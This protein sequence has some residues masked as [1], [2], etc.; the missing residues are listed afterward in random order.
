MRKSN[1]L[2]A[3]LLFGLLAALAAHAQESAD[4]PVELNPDHPT[5]YVV[6]Q[7]DTLWSIAKQFLKEPWRWPHVWH[8]NPQISNPHL[9]YP[10]DTIELTITE[11]GPVLSLGRGSE[12]RISPRVRTMA[13]EKAIPAIPIDAIHQFLTRPLVVNEGELEAAPYV[14]ALQE[15]HIIG[16]EGNRIYVRG[17]DTQEYESFDVVR[18]G[19]PYKDGV[20]GEILGYE[21]LYVGDARLDRAGD[22]ATLTLTATRQHVSVGDRVLPAVDEQAIQTFYPK[23]PETDIDGRIIDVL[24]GVTTIGRYDVVVIDRGSDNGLQIGDVLSV[25]RTG[26]TIRDRISSEPFAEVKLPDEQA[27]ALMIFR[28]FPMVSFGLVMEAGEDL[29]IGER[30]VNP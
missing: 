23:P 9:I 14:V 29:E 24:E 4:A 20:T 19:N 12:V 18:P 8:A 5:R 13:V 16:G 28:T 1:R 7:G 11:G 15:G 10:G 22:P 25:V 30:V 27:G 26:S 3:G 2:I 21:G 6:K 17:I